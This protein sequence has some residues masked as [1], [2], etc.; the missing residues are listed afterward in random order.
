MEIKGKLFKI[1][2]PITGQGKSGE[3][4]KQDFVI[5]LESSSN[6]PRRAC[7]T[8]WGDKV[9]VDALVEDAVVNVFFDIESREYQD[10]WFTNLTAWRV[11]VEGGLQTPQP[12]QPM[13][14]M[15]VYDAEEA[16]KDDLPF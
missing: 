13:P 4:K 7:F 2:A 14:T 8:V 5:E 6:Y 9:N 11:D 12:Q 1:L 3:W 15:E 10:K 16:P